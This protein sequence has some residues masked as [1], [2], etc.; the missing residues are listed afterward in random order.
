MAGDER[1]PLRWIGPSEFADPTAATRPLP[2]VSPASAVPV[3]TVVIVTY[4]PG[5]SLATCLRSLRHAL[6][7]PYEVLIVDNGSSDGAPQRAAERYG[8]RF[9]E[10][11][12]N[13]GYGAAANIGAAESDASWLLVVNPDTEFVPGSLTRM[14]AAASRWPR[15]GVFGPA[16]LA[17][18][19]QLYPSARAIPSLSAGVGH[20]LCVRWWP[21]NPW[22]AAYRREGQLPVEGPTGWLSGACMLFRAEAFAAVGGFD[23]RYFMYFEDLDVCERL[24]TAGWESIYVPSA[25][26]RHVGG[27]STAKVPAAMTV[28]H[29]RSAVRYLMGRYP[30]VR[31]APLRLVLRAGL[32]VRG[33]ILSRRL[34]DSAP[35]LESAS[36]PAAAP[37]TA[38]EGID[39][40]LPPRTVDLRDQAAGHRQPPAVID[41]TENPRV[42]PAGSADAPRPYGG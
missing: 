17:A 14:L 33:R 21:S 28:A 3:V 5:D 41:L 31:H 18:D 8:A 6:D 22:T 19:G 32:A 35:G 10:T 40:S 24:T 1:D 4:Q 36:A 27:L 2:V 9:I 42:S 26:I 25:V 39:L 20:A 23:E 11:G 38:P 29:H 13:A 15:G 34:T 7:V 16:L 30:K 12:R 37:I